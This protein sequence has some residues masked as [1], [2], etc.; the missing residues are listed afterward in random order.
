MLVHQL[1]CHGYSASSVRQWA[2]AGYAPA[3]ALLANMTADPRECVAL[4]ERAAAQGDRD[5]LRL[6]GE[7]L[8]TGIL[9][10]KNVERA[11]VCLTEA[12]KLGQPEAQFMCGEWLFR[13]NQKKKYFWLGCSAAHGYGEAVTRL[14]SE[15][16]RQVKK[17]AKGRTG[18]L[19]SEVG[20]V[21]KG[22]VD[23]RKK[24]FF[25]VAMDDDGLQAVQQC[26]DVH[27]HCTFD[28]FLELT[29]DFYGY[30][31][32]SL[33]LEASSLVLTVAAV[34]CYTGAFVVA[35]GRTNGPTR[36]S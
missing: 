26:I 22:H 15:A 1:G 33:A 19:V 23:F 2:E 12:A 36:K 21:C 17:F 8:W 18:R 24:I 31:P 29:V 14:R 4:A 34:L 35:A 20:A 27:L 6:L 25:G 28:F 10:E 9:C 7:F 3:L 16:V 30:H 5:G 13:H 11:N 32:V